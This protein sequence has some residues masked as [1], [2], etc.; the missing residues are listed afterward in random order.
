MKQQRRCYSQTILS[1]RS[2]AVPQKL[3]YTHT[4]IHARMWMCVC[5]WACE[6]ENSQQ[7]QRD[8]VVFFILFWRQTSP[9]AARQD[10]RF[11]SIRLVFSLLLLLLDRLVRIC[12]HFI[13]T[14]FCHSCNYTDI[15]TYVCVY[16]DRNV[17]AYV[18]RQIIILGQFC[19]G[20]SILF[21]VISFVPFIMGIIR[22]RLNYI[23]ITCRLT[24]SNL[25]IN[26]CVGGDRAIDVYIEHSFL[27]PFIYKLSP[28][29]THLCMYIHTCIKHKRT[30]SFIHTYIHTHTHIIITITT[31]T[32]YWSANNSTISAATGCAATTTS[33]CSTTATVA[34]TSSSCPT[35]ST[36]GASE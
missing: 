25:L 2:C 3:A 20:F 23:D 1:L 6:R 34:T 16:V 22:K 8:R 7:Q 19:C 21:Y 30:H 35:E 17:H 15:H 4:H 31:T 12:V 33:G 11:L 14:I 13:L 36:T 28:I 32:N 5:M 27:F 29:L 24:S 26:R 9:M 10:L 18:C